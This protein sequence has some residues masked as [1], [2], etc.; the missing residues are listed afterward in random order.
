MSIE[1]FHI[2]VDFILICGDIYDSHL[3]SVR[4]N[5][6]FIDQCVRLGE[7]NISV[8]VIYGNHDAMNERKN[9]LTMPP[10]CSYFKL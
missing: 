1:L 9:C 3:R 5:K 2:K 6:F 8:Y 7:K 4:G 10:K